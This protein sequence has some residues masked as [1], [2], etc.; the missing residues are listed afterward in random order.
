MKHQMLSDV[1][2]VSLRL[3]HNEWTLLTTVVVVGGDTRPCYSTRSRC[4]RIVHFMESC[5]LW[6][7]RHFSE[8]ALG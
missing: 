5:R 1:T 7:E 4:T 8:S 3:H 2:G 6:F